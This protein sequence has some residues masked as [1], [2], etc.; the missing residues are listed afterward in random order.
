[1]PEAAGVPGSGDTEESE[2]SPPGAPS[3]VGGERCGRAGGT[4]QIFIKRVIWAV[5]EVVQ[6][7]VDPKGGTYPSLEV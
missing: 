3:P 5:M 1:M 7:I 4:A 2:P 6:D